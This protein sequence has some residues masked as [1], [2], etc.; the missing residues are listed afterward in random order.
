[1]SEELRVYPRHV[2][3]CGFCLMP[4]ARNWFR[5]HNLDW[6]DFLMNGIP[7]SRL[8]GIDDGL[9]Q[10]AKEAAIAEAKS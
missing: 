8:E 6:R 5:L 1:M 9:C 3:A 4:G 10:R 2:Q 7:F